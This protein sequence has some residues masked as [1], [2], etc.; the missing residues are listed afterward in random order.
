MEEHKSIHNLRQQKILD[1][2]STN[3]YLSVLDLA[4]RFNVSE[5]T[6]R[7]DL[8]LLENLGL[9]SRKHG[10]VVASQDSIIVEEASNISKVNIN[11]A[12]KQA[13]AKAAMK[14][15][16]NK[17]LI[18]LAPGT[19]VQYL[20]NEIINS[21]VTNLSVLSSTINTSVI[22]Q[23][24][25]NVNLMQVGG[26]IRM[27]SGAA[28]GIYSK[29]MIGNYFASKL[30]FGADGIDPSF[31]ISTSTT[32]EVELNRMMIENS[33][34]VILLA[35]S[36]KIG[37]RGFS[38]IIGIED[39]DILITDSQIDKEDYNGIRELGVEIIIAD[40]S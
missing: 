11:I 19:T 2:L 7:K 10:G 8:R 27:S 5:V 33:E 14:L 4:T 31:G 35:D 25:P 26:D 28:V 30:F 32:V 38:K 37:K 18:S 40:E 16:K 1:V 17:D 22:L 34:K 9:V 36:S 39:L 3:N 24:N 20:A 13:I 21:N 6:I 15:I 29:L 23:N 12:Q